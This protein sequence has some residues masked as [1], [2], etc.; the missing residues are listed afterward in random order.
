MQ[1]YEPFDTRIK[2]PVQSA[3]RLIKLQ[4]LIFFMHTLT[5][6]AEAKGKKSQQGHT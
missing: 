5:K 6:K 2:F 4:D 3:K 1:S